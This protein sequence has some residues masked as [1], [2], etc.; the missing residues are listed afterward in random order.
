[1]LTTDL[2]PH[3]IHF[4]ALLYFVCFL[5]RDQIKLRLFAIAG[6]FAYIAYYFTAA[7]HPLW[8]AIGWA[9]ANVLVNIS[10]ILM[11][12]RDHRVTALS[13]DELALFQDMRGLTPGQFRR[14]ARL[15][16]WQVANGKET[17]TE[18][19]QPLDRLYYLAEG[20]A[21]V[22]KSGREI[23]LP[24]ASFIGELAYLRQKPATATVTARP[25]AKLVSWSHADLARLTARDQ[26]LAAALSALL[27]NDM[28]EKVARG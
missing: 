19:G 15:G 18:E 12:L 21:D 23:L 5:F 28:A 8:E 14:L 24:R 2:L 3:L 1:M 4:G 27:S 11:I 7:E 10:M 20:E 17:L 13:D 16:Q 25:G 22:E 26:S 6:D 9:S